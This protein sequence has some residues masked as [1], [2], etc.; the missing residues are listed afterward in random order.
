MGWLNFTIEARSADEVT[1]ISE[2]VS[3]PNAAD[4][5]ADCSQLRATH[6]RPAPLAVK[7]CLFDCTRPRVW[8]LDDQR[9]G[10]AEAQ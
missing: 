3:T 7:S 6:P 2:P 8:S 1:C 4:S 5:S 9:R 10:V